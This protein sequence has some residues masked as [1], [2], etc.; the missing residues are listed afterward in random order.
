MN[1]VINLELPHR[2]IGLRETQKTEKEY[3]AFQL[4]NIGGEPPKYDETLFKEYIPQVSKAL[5]KDV[6]QKLMEWVR[7]DKLQGKVIELFFYHRTGGTLKVMCDGEVYCYYLVVPHAFVDSKFGAEIAT[8]FIKE[9]QNTLGVPY[10]VM[11]NDVC[12]F[13]QWN[14]FSFH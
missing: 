13:V 12:E 7:T 8:A 2:R 5:A 6:T 4:L 1:D 11:K 14:K 9:F 3:E 10:K